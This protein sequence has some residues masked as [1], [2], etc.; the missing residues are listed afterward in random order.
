MYPRN[1]GTFTRARLCAFARLRGGGRHVGCSEH[2]R[3]GPDRTPFNHGVLRA[4][5]KKINVNSRVPVVTA[6][7]RFYFDFVLRNSTYDETLPNGISHATE[8]SLLCRW[9]QRSRVVF[10]ILRAYELSRRDDT[11]TVLQG[12][13]KRICALPQ[14]RRPPF[15]SLGTEIC[16]SNSP[17]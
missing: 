11:I 8:F 1:N 15:V 6:G 3:D 4:T 14:T 17:R 16:L 13:Q 12:W 10:A 5:R 2:A 9:S 7:S